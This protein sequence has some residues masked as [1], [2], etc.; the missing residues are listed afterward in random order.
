MDNTQI[1][2]TYYLQAPY[3]IFLRPNKLEVEGW[4]CIGV[5]YR[6]G[7]EH[8]K[9]FSPFFQSQPY[10][11]WKLATSQLLQGYFNDF[12]VRVHLGLMHLTSNQY[13]VPIY[14]SLNRLSKF[15]ESRKN[16]DIFL[17]D[18][19]TLFNDGLEGVN[20]TATASLINKIEEYSI[21]NRVFNI[22]QENALKLMANYSNSLDMTKVNPESF[23]TR[24]GL[25]EHEVDTHFH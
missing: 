25:T 13:N 9:V 4:I 1:Q 21:L 10:K 11:V 23:I 14:N 24:N 7:H 19:Y 22:S 16:L 18:A 2:E 12:H 3:P 5:A 15:G 20:L 17:R 8:I 6:Y